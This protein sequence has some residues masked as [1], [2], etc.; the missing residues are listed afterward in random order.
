MNNPENRTIILSEIDYLLVA[1]FAEQRDLSNQ[2]AV[3]FL[4]ER[5]VDLFSPMIAKRHALFRATTTKV[6]PRTDRKGV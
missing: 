4:I 1:D 6:R 5:A 2:E 3:S